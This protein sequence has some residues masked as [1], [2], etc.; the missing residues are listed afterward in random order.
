MASALEYAHRQGILHRDVKPANLLLDSAATSGSPTSAWPNSPAFPTT[1]P[2]TGDVIGTLQYLAPE[3]LKSEADARARYLWPGDYALRTA[4]L[5][6]CLRRLQSRGSA[7]QARRHR[8]CPAPQAQPAIPQDLENIVLKAI[9]RDPAMRYQTAGELAEDFDNFIHDRP[10]NARRAYF[11][12]RMWRWGRRNRLVASLATVAVVCAIGAIALGWI[13]YGTTRRALIAEANRYTVS[14]V[15]KRNAEANVALSL[16][17]FEEIFNRLT[18][19]GSQP[20]PPDARPG[21]KSHAKGIA[22]RSRPQKHSEL[23]R[24]VCRPEQHQR[25]ARS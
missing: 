1:S 25:A 18:A 19:T 7:P 6:T 14:E 21:S 11:V 9:A 4:Y 10:I 5:P 2:Q 12:E 20:P 13:A 23:L 3:G 22:G 15:A 16:R 24:S 8:A 17:S